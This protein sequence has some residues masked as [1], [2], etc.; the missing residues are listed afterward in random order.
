MEPRA[1]RYFS[2]EPAAEPV[3]VVEETVIVV[4]DEGSGR[5]RARRRKS[6]R[7]APLKASGATTCKPDPSP[8]PMS[9]PPV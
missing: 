8:T 3:L 5:K 9:P 7:T 6:R 4:V 2:P 1:E